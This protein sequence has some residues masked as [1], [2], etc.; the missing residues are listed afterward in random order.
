MKEIYQI[1]SIFKRRRQAVERFTALS[2]GWF[3]LRLFT[4]GAAQFGPKIQ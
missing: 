1:P 4:K 3:A 2:A